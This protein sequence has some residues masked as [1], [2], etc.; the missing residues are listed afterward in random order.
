MTDE[1]KTT[2]KEEVKQPTKETKPSDTKGDSIKAEKPAV[3]KKEKELDRTF[4]E[5]KPGCVVKVHHEITDV[6]PKGEEKK[7]VQI[8]EGIVTARKHGKGINATITVRKESGGIGVEKIYPL[9]LPSVKKIEIIKKWRARRA[10][11]GYLKGKHK[12]L[13]EIEPGTK[14]T[15]KR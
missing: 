14:R 1:K 6:N 7:R 2:S 3:E 5:V 12:R 10:K 4:P 9:S 13:R 15:R 8:F 11:L